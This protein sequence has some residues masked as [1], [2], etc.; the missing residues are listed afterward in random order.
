MS[1][2]LERLNEQEQ[3]RRAE[4]ALSLSEAKFAAAFANNPAAIALTRLDD[5]LALDVN[6]TWGQICGYNRE[7]I[8][9]RSL[10][11]MWPSPE[12]AKGFVAELRE[13]GRVSYEQ[14]FR[15]KS[16]E[17]FLAQLTAQKLKINGEQVILST[18]I[19][20]T[21]HKRIQKALH[22]SE[23]KYRTLFEK[24]T[25]AI[26][27][28]DPACG[29]FTSGNAAALKMFG[30][31][32]EAA[33]LACGPEDLSPERQP[34]GRLSAEAA[35]EFVERGQREGSLD[36]DWT[37]RRLSGEEFFAEVLLTRIELDGK[38]F[39]LATL[40]DVSARK[41]AEALLRAS[42]EEKTA[43]LKEVHHRV[44]NNLQVVASLLNL[45]ASQINNPAILSALRDTQGR[46]RS[47]ALLH[48][49]LY[50]EDNVARAN[51]AAYLGHLCTYLIQTF[52][53]ES[54]RIRLEQRIAPVELD[55]DNAIPC[56]L[57]VNELVSNAFKHAFPGNRS[58]QIT[59]ELRLD[60]NGCLVLS[61]ADDGVGLPAGSHS[62][63][64]GSL[65]MKLIRGLAS[66]INASLDIKGPPGTV[67]QIVLPAQGPRTN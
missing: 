59:V 12:A 49:T 29:K 54:G 27:M 53:P 52:G 34:D 67:T 40:R 60:A 47:M 37:H 62:G 66:Q 35:R 38:P 18:F 4:Q 36:F 8:K 56:G 7:E 17:R 42:L 44:K 58:G 46:I 28:L 64:P 14:E 16:G 1:D 21:A 13:K 41:R 55:L 30:A 39:H 57:I 11:M 33:L 24:L 25:D 6:N 15:K 50:N 48:E 5:G 10:R 51:C 32:S 31:E 20:I 45:Q 43:L 9:G 19:D 22:D 26:M 3:R 23:R 65:G 63:R 2:A 61:V